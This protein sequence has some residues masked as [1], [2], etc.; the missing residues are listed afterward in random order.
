MTQTG[1]APPRSFSSF[2]YDG[3]DGADEREHLARFQQFSAM[4]PRDHDFSVPAVLPS[5]V[6]ARAAA[7]RSRSVSL[8]L[9]MEPALLGLTFASLSSLQPCGRP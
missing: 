3:A 1:G 5:A 9:P 6:S 8:M 2:G 4:L 7:R